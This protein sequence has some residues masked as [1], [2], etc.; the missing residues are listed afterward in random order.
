[1][2]RKQD[3]EL[4]ENEYRIGQ[5]TIRQLA[6]KHKVATSSITRRAAKHGWTRD[7]SAA[8]QAET[9]ARLVSES[10]DKRIQNADSAIATAAQTNVTVVMGHRQDIALLRSMV[11][12]MVTKIRAMGLVDD[13]GMTGLLA[14][15]NENGMDAAEAKSI[16]T[17]IRNTCNTP[18]QVGA[19]KNLSETLTKLVALEREAFG[20]DGEAKGGGKDVDPATLPPVAAVLAILQ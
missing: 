3:W 19:L 4:I 18:A 12:D 16:I 15:I 8:V 13:I 14:I 6:D 17:T 10:A 7:L 9:R 11:G 1:M 5:L 2:A 20:I